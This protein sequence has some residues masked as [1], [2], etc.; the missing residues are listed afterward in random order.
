VQRQF[1]KLVVHFWFP[2][3]I[4]EKPGHLPHL[5]Q[6]R[7]DLGAGFVVAR[8]GV[9]GSAILMAVVRQRRFCWWTSSVDLCLSVSWD[10]A[11]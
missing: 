3:T 10:S 1:I 2:G 5:V 11:V 7:C 9:F 6:C 4:K 8:S